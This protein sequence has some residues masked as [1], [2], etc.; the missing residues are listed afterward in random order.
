MS[1]EHLIVAHEATEAIHNRSSNDG[2][3]GKYPCVKEKRIKEV[4]SEI[5]RLWMFS[6]GNLFYARDDKT[7][8]EGLDMFFVEEKKRAGKLICPVCYRS[9][10]YLI[11]FCFFFVKT[12]LIGETLYFL[13]P[14]PPALLPELQRYKDTA[15]CGALGMEVLG[16]RQ[17][18]LTQTLIVRLLKTHFFT[19]I[20]DFEKSTE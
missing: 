9:G 10:H 1:V 6:V 3:F 15:R 20:L 7:L 17:Q 14:L 18:Q 13:G 12:P 8:A 4:A 11:F 5:L 19:S 2:G 16:H